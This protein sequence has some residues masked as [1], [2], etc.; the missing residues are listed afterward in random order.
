M[1]LFDQWGYTNF[2]ELNLEWILRR[3]KDLTSMVENFVALNTIKYADPIQWSIIRQYE[4]NTVVVDPQSGT[5]YLSSRPVPKGV[6]LSNDYYWSVIFTLDVI[7]ANK[8]LTLRDDGS[9]VLATFSSVAGDWLLWNGTLY[10]V[11]QAI[12]VNEAYV[13]GYNLDRYTIEMFI[14][15]YISSISADI[16]DIINNMGD[17][18]SL[19]TTD[20]TSIVNALNEVVSNMGS[21]LDLDTVDKS[22]IVAA[23]NELANEPQDYVNVLD[24]GA[25]NTRLYYNKADNQYYADSAFTIQPTSSVQAFTDA[26]A[27]ARANNIRTVFIPRGWYY[28]PAFTMTVEENDIILKGEGVGTYLVSTGLTTGQSFITVDATDYLEDY[29][30]GGNVLEGFTILGN[31]YTNNFAASRTANIRAVTAFGGNYPHHRNI[32]GVN[33]MRFDCAYYINSAIE[34]HIRNSA[35]I[36]NNCGFR[37][38]TSNTYVPDPLWIEECEIGANATGIFAPNGGY[39]V[40]HIINC[41]IGSNRMVYAG[42]TAVYLSGCRMELGFEEC[43]DDSGNSFYPWEFSAGWASSSPSGNTSLTMVNCELLST[44]GGANSIRTLLSNA[45]TYTRNTPYDLIDWVHFSGNLAD[46][47]P[48]QVLIASLTNCRYSFGSFMVGKIINAEVGRVSVNGCTSTAYNGNI[49]Q[50]GDNLVAYGYIGLFG[51]FFT[52]SGSNYVSSGGTM[53]IDVPLK[54]K[55][56]ILH[57]D[58][59]TDATFTITAYHDA[60]ALPSPLTKAALASPTN[61]ANNNL[62]MILPA[63]TNNV[64]ITFPACTFAQVT[65]AIEILS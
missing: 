24:F 54:T 60:Q 38:I 62:G 33:V 25:V 49:S 43:C 30:S 2:H 41:G 50:F 27:Y 11:S 32:D 22:S 26:I 12:N 17:I 44:L 1:S 35:I 23:I 53:S 28:L 51:S 8:N 9:N 6:A 18:T 36:L 20:K 3:M 19:T 65:A 59:T 21:L 52:A 58:P 55:A 5:A 7:S 13:V 42:K 34:T 39:A 57:V 56:I 14:S 48:S 29:A 40:I 4:A 46:V 63:G 45:P 15:D 47:A 16:A 64:K 10:K 61:K 37:F 31:Y